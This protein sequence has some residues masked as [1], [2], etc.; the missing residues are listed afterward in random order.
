MRTALGFPDRVSWSFMSFMLA[1]LIGVPLSGPLAAQLDDQALQ[2]MVGTE[3]AFAAATAEVGVRDG[4]LAFF[5]PDAVTIAAGKDGA[6]AVVQPARPG[7]VARPLAKLPLLSEL[8]WA[9][10]TGQISSDGAMGWLTGA[11]VNLTKLDHRI[12]ARG[13]YFSVWKRQADGLYRVWLDEG[14][15]LPQT[16]DNAGD[17][18]V[19][20]D[21]DTGA[22]GAPSETLD[23]AERSVAAG[24]A[25]WRARL[26]HDVRLHRD[27]EMPFV[28]R[29]AASAWA[30]VLW[31]N[32]AFAPLKIDEA[33]SHD[34][35]L[36]MGGYDAGAEHGTWIRV[37]KRDV[38]GR[39]RIVF[40][41]SK[42]AN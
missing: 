31:S 5:A 6:G 29:D 32:V 42:R 15:S 36:T 10:F 17:F 8:M 34:L 1:F 41:T 27:G 11:Y 16:W 26:S 3:R 30:G 9:P 37:W 7:L 25:A 20:P 38:T 22:A 2:R 13:A 12:T 19:A 40:E 4:F 24:G 39:Y 23:A 35:G 33:A 14:I 28:G 21:P 18:R